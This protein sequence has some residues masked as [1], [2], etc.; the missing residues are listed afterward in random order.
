MSESVENTKK[1]ARIAFIAKHF[2]R[3]R[4][5][6]KLKDVKIQLFLFHI[7][8]ERGLSMGPW[9]NKRSLKW[10]LKGKSGST[11]GILLVEL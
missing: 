4:N 11:T 9:G 2:K 6:N 7:L 1:L 10:L 8:I 3:G 5:T